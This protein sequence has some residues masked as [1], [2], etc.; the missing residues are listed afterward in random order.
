MNL[1]K[2]IE[3]VYSDSDPTNQI[4]SLFGLL[5]EHDDRVRSERSD[6]QQIRSLLTSQ[7]IN[8]IGIEDSPNMYRIEQEVQNYKESKE[9]INASDG[10]W[11]QEKTDD[12]LYLLY[13]IEIKLLAEYPS[14]I[15]LDITDTDKT[16]VIP[17][18]SETVIAKGME[19][20]NANERHSKI[21]QEMVAG[22]ENIY[23]LIEL[24]RQARA[25]NNFIFNHPSFLDASVFIDPSDT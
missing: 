3:I 8:W 21:T 24:R 7:E 9:N 1:T 2:F 23:D 12:L 22:S 14:D 11:N 13:H 15:V 20:I 16:R 19:L 18:E 25:F 17:L 6:F 10:L 4:A 5:R